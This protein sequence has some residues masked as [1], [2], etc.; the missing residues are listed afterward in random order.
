MWR[1][2]FTLVHEASQEAG[3]L[4]AR[5]DP[6][7]SYQKLLILFGAPTNADDDIER[8]LACALQAA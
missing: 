7:D 3:G 5:S 8:A 2:V 1:D 6:G 4:W